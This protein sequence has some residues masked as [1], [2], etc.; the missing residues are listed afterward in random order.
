MHPK[1]Q[2]SML[3]HDGSY[4]AD[5]NRYLIFS[6][7][8]VFLS[9]FLG[10]GVIF[11][12]ARTSFLLKENHYSIGMFK[13]MSFVGNY[14]SDSLHLT[15]AMIT[16]CHCKQQTNSETCSVNETQMSSWRQK[17][18]VI[19]LKGYVIVIVI[20]ILLTFHRPQYNAYMIQNKSVGTYNVVN[21]I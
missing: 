13:E 1:M 5:D 17:R 12:A 18:T 7:H 2:F 9:Q 6:L 16:Y 20:V 14:I 19:L 11:Q 10:S 21:I 8:C 4:R 3:C 15:L